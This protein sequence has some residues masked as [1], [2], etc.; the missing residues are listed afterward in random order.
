MTAGRPRVASDPE[1]TQEAPARYRGRFAPSPTGP[2]HF[3]SLVAAIASYLQ[4]LVNDGEWL[5]RIENIDP[6]REVEGATAA[7]VRSLQAHGFEWHGDILYQHE[8]DHRFNDV[9]SML[10]ERGQAYP[11]NCTREQV[12]TS[13]RSGKAGPIYP[14]TCAA[15]TAPLDAATPVAIRVRTSGANLT[16]TDLL[17]GHNDCEVEKEIGDFIVRRKDGL[18]GYN[19]A[20]VVD[21]H[22]Q[23]ITEIV[24]G[25]DLL[26]FTPA[27]IH[28][29]R[30]LG[31]ETPGYMH[32][33]VVLNRDGKKLSKQT[34]ALAL[35]DSRAARNLVEGL[36]LLA[37][38][39]SANLA[40][41][42]LD[43]IWDWARHHWRP[44]NLR[45]MREIPKQLSM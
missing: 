15:R 2:L 25:A 33:P 11:C 14:G 22:D 10:L 29:Q 30:V 18:I 35:S 12:R 1:S 24:R 26:D 43:D 38:Q 21:D 44:E 9:V 4:A 7:I 19:L 16:F 27:Q 36:D 13:A 23:R 41:A 28:L 17:Q 32:V 31:F 20:V 42:S 39:P 40:S 37:Q 8:H 45:G 3:G 5:L 6:P 34:G